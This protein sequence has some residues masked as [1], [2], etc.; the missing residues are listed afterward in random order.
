LVN[1][2]IRLDFAGTSAQVDKG[3]NCT[4]N[5]TTAF[6]VHALKCALL[7][8]VPNNDGFF[9][10]IEV[11]APL[12]CILNARWPAAVA[13]RHMITTFVSSCVFG[14]V[15]RASVLSVVAVTYGRVTVC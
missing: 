6:V 14:A 15:G 4:L 10:P 13:A 12:G 11:T 9:V 8:D 2:K 5:V 7:P 1:N 3:V